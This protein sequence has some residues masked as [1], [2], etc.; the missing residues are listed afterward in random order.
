MGGGRRDLQIT[1]ATS[2]E[3]SVGST[4]CD[5]DWSFHSLHGEV[6]FHLI[7]CQLIYGLGCCNTI[8]LFRPPFI[9]GRMGGRA[10]EAGSGCSIRFVS[11]RCRDG[12]GAG[13]E[14]VEHAHARPDIGSGLNFLTVHVPVGYR[15]GNGL[16]MGTHA[17]GRRAACVVRNLC[18]TYLRDIVVTPQVFNYP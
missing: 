8:L 6:G 4:S 15:A 2:H 13:S 5:L 1:P 18:I 9:H 11:L 17:E 16:P 10:G 7:C 14:R 3:F 12:N